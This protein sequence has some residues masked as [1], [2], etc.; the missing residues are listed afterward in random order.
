MSIRRAIV[1][2]C[3]VIVP[4]MDE[5]IPRT[6]TVINF[7]LGGL[8]STKYWFVLEFLTKQREVP[9]IIPSKTILNLHRFDL[10]SAPRNHPTWDQLVKSPTPR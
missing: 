3:A 1:K 8:S 5:E 7:T 6:E 10:H 2:L 9:W 4:R